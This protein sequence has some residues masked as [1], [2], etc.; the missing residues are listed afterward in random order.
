MVFLQTSKIIMVWIKK[1]PK[2]YKINEATPEAAE[3]GQR[4]EE[5]WM[6]LNLELWYHVTNK[7]RLNWII[8]RNK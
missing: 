5:W 3:M 8:T 2:K 6:D 4:R 1:N 7:E